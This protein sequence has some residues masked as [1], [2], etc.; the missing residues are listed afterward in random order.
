MGGWVVVVVVVV[1][2]VLVVRIVV[3]SLNPDKQNQVLQRKGQPL[4]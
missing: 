2:V 1:W 4:G 3:P